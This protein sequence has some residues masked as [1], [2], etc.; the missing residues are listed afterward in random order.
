MSVSSSSHQSLN[1]EGRWGTID[2]FATSFLH[3]PCS[4]LPS[5]TWRTP[6]LFISRCCL[7]TSSV[8][9]FFFPLSLCL[10]RWFLQDLMNER[11]VHTTEVCVSL[12][13][14][15][16]RCGLVA[17][18]ILAQTSSLV[19]WSLYEMRSILRWHLISMTCVLLWSSAVR[20]HDSQA[21]RKMDV[22]NTQVIDNQM[23]CFCF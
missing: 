15:G 6:G 10:A 2:D 19:T 3:F 12:R 1:R 4:P 18:W 16:L 7:P 20:V 9:R 14:S 13:W 17:C 23:H 21:C 8:C 11:H 5:G 22:T